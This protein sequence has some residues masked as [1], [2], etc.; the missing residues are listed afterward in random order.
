MHEVW[1]LPNLGSDVGEMGDL[2]CLVDRSIHI[3]RNN[4]VTEGVEMDIVLLGISG[5]HENAFCSTVKEDW[6]V[7]D[8]VACW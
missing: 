4:R 6:S 1:V 3:S 2:S 5:V 8:F 7:D